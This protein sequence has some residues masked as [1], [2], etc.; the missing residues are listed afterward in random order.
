MPNATELEV[1][2]CSLCNS[3][4]LYLVICCSSV[5]AILSCSEPVYIDAVVVGELLK[6]RL[7][8]GFRVLVAA[9]FLQPYRWYC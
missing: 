8:V 3:I 1:A 6:L 7:R 4:D 5:V 2:R 9:H